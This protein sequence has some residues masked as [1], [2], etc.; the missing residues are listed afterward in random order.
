MEYF[1]SKIIK[2]PKSVCDNKTSDDTHDTAEVFNQSIH[3][4]YISNNRGVRLNCKILIKIL[5]G[6]SPKIAYVVVVV[7]CFSLV[8]DAAQHF[9]SL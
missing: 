4:T 7:E 2:R 9:F 5:F 1:L 3:L 6:N 8:S